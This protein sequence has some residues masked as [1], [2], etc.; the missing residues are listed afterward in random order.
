MGAP[1]CNINAPA[2]SAEPNS[3]RLPTI[4]VATDLASAIAAI[5]ALRQIVQALTNQIPVNT[6]GR[7]GAVKTQ[8]SLKEQVSKRTTEMVRVFNPQ[9]KSQF[10]DVEQI[11]HLQFQDASSGQTLVWDRPASSDA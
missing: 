3:P 6:L 5:N 11:N 2:P 4:P 9:D 1:V 8:P 10:V 7:Q